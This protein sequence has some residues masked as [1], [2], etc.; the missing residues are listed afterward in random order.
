MGKGDTHVCGAPNHALI[1]H[2]R[3]HAPVRHEDGHAA[4]MT[5]G[6]DELVDGTNFDDT[7]GAANHCGA[8]YA[9]E[10]TGLGPTL[11]W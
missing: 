10:A 3:T 2:G 9:P 6:T 5:W 11:L 8:A 4:D 7:I 1:D